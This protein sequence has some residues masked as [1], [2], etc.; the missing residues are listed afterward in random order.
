MTR[1][2]VKEDWY[3]KIFL[4]TIEVAGEITG[5]LDYKNVSKLVPLVE[6]EMDFK[7]IGKKANKN[8]L[9]DDEVPLET[10]ILLI[11]SRLVYKI[12]KKEITSSGEVSYP[13][14]YYITSLFNNYLKIPTKK[15]TRKNGLPVIDSITED[16][17]V[18]VLVNIKGID[19]YV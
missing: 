11:I 7:I 12:H 16:M 1:K 2:E 14:D 13:I 5:N 8:A 19:D 9:T 18:D 3:N 15:F 17:R 6:N 10:F 4:T